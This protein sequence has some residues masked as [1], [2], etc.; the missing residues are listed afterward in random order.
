MPQYA[1]TLKIHKGVDNQLQFQFLN[2][3]QKP[4]DITGKEI[5]CRIIS[6]EGNK[7]LIKK[8]LTLQFALNGIGALFLKPSEIEGIDAQKCYYSLEIPINDFKYPVFVDPFSGARGDVEICNSVLPSFVPSEEVSIPT[9]Q[10]MPDPTL[11][12]IYSNQQITYYSSTINTQDSNCLTLQVSYR[13]YSGNV[14][15][16]GSTLQSSGWY[17]ISTHS[18]ENI[19]DTL[20]YNV[21]GYHPW[22]RLKFQSSYGWVFDIKAR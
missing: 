17:P 15:V 18:Y 12:D 9:G 16:E 1:K 10:V 5:V 14:V 4:V 7:T 20:G 21:N 13:Q 19:T 22:V 11:C 3:Q 2:Q 8:A 6:N